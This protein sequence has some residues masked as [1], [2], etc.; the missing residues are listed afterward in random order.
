MILQTIPFGRTALRM[1]SGAIL[2]AAHFTAIYSVTALACARGYAHAMVFGLELVTL[3]VLAATLLAF[4]TALAIVRRA[5]RADA[6]SFESW[7]TATV[8]S[9]AAVAIVWEGFVPVLVLPACV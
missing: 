3:T 7:I 1:W 9:L 2:W 5:R 6:A 8:A 4:L